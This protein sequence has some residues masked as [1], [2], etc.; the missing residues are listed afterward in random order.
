MFAYSSIEHAGIIMLGLAG[1]VA[2]KKPFCILF[3]TPLLTAFL[4]ARSDL[5]YLSKQ[6]YL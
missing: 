1:G 2:I 5:P 4:S 6:E 3:Y